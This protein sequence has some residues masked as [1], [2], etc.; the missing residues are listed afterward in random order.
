[1]EVDAPETTMLRRRIVQEKVF[2]RRL[3]EEWYSQ[4]ALAL[5]DLH[6]PV[7]E[8][9]SGAGFMGNFIEDLITSEVFPTPGAR[10][11]LDGA[12][13]PFGDSAL[14]AVVMTDVF[15]HIPAP[16]SF[17]AEARRALKPG[18]RIVMVEPWV[19]PW[20]RFVYR[21]F[22]HEPFEPDA[23][24]WEFPPA[25][26]LSGANGAL[27]WI[28]FERDRAIFETE[29]PELVIRRIS[30][31]M[32]TVYLVSGGVSLRSLAPSFAYPILRAAERALPPL[33]RATAMFA[34]ITVEKMHDTSAAA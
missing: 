11:V 34:L 5:P 3:Y 26:P 25:G 29:F 27:P 8:L 6:G 9:G 1:M 31:L 13:L 4:I 21:N 30:P 24:A 16:R 22:H 2:L 10:V 18:G 32:P 7:L 20:S 12:R 33:E 19:T 14:R 28:I 23:V 15:H 17:L